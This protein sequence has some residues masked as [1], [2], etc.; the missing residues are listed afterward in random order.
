MPE[1]PAVINTRCVIPVSPICILFARIRSIPLCFATSDS[2]LRQ[3]TPQ[4]PA[5]SHAGNFPRPSL[6]S[7]PDATNGLSAALRDLAMWPLISK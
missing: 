1:A 4:S 3:S 5:C 7:L 6:L 2:E